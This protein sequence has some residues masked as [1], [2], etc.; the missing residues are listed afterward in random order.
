MMNA[1]KYIAVIQRKMVK[2]MERAF[3]NGGGIF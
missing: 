1:D 3:P 2:D